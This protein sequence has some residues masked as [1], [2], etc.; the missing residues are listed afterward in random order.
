MNYYICEKPTECYCLSDCRSIDETVQ[1]TPLKFWSISAR[2][3]VQM[4]QSQSTLSDPAQNECGKMDGTES[5][6]FW[7]NFRLDM[8]VLWNLSAWTTTTHQHYELI[9]DTWWGLRT[10]SDRCP[11]FHVLNLIEYV[12]LW[13]DT[14]ATSD[15]DA[16]PRV[17]PKLSSTKVR[18]TLSNFYGTKRF[19]RT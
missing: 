6:W 12:Q 4:D 18:R 7:L 8:E 15:S 11:T 14:G 13:G 9:F 5:R 19:C 1:Q 16:V 3:H 17:E 2:V 10:G